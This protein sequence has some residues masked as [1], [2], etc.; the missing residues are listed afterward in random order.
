L[1]PFFKGVFSDD[2]I[3]SSKAISILSS[4]DAA[5]TRMKK[6]FLHPSLVKKAA[7]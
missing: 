7:F 4:W 3:G 6:R 5:K 1:I 2:L